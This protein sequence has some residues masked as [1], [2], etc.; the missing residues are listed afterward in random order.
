[1]KQ[2]LSCSKFRGEK[3]MCDVTCTC[4]LPKPVLLAARMSRSQSRSHAQLFCVRPH[5]FL[6]KRET[7]RSLKFQRLS[8]YTQEDCQALFSCLRYLHHL[9]TVILCKWSNSSIAVFQRSV[10]NGVRVFLSA[11][12]STCQFAPI[13]RTLHCIRTPLDQKSPRGW[14]I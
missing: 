14:W 2:S 8:S 6:I 9:F 3:R 12:G 7:S 5:R 10:W 11:P 13:S 4:E 1:M